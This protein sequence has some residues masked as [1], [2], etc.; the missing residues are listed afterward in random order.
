MKKVLL[1]IGTVV[2]LIG[3]TIYAD[4]ATRVKAK[5]SDGQ[6]VAKA[7]P[8]DAPVPEVTFKDLDGKEVPLS[9]YKGKVVLVNFWA[10]WCEPCQVEIPWLIEMQQKYSSTTM[11]LR[12]PSR[13]SCNSGNLPYPLQL[14]GCR[15]NAPLSPSAVQRACLTTVNSWKPSRGLIITDPAIG[16]KILP[17]SGQ[18]GENRLTI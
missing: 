2:V 4:R 12:T 7:D 15:T 6:D 3:L 8:A 5:V 11:R 14:T 17:D 9:Q 1:I 18:T 16:A 10:T 13:A